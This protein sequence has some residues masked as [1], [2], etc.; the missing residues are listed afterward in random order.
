MDDFEPLLLATETHFS[1]YWP[2]VKPLLERCVKRAMRGEMTVDDIYAAARQGRM[3]VFVVKSDKAL[4]A[5]VKLALVLELVNYPRLPTMNIVAIGGSELS[6]MHKR[7]W[8]SLCGW[9][10]MNGVRAI[11]CRVSP[12]MM[13]VIVRYGFKETYTHMRVDVSEDVI[14]ERT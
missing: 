5:S 9:A 6:V 13:R 4:M 8:K 2:V 14:C 7:F 11:E 12:A 10:Y 1:Q 3:Y